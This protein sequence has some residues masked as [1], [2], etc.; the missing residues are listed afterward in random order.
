[1]QEEEEEL[2]KMQEMGEAEMKLLCKLKLREEEEEMKS[3]MERVAVVLES[4]DEA[5]EERSP[6]EV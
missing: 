6:A 1:M 2:A 3:V 4:L 5:E